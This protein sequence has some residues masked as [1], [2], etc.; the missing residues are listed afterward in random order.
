MAK[1]PTIKRI[2]REDLPDAPDWI[3]KLLY[4]VNKFFEDVFNALNRNLEFVDNVT[5]QKKDVTFK[6]LSTYVSTSATFETLEFPRTLKR[7][8]TG[9]LLL[10]IIQDED[11]H[12]PIETAPYIDW[13]DENGTI[14]IFLVT[15]LV[16]S[17]TYNMRVLL[18]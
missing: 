3:D 13:L 12:T 11:N 6:T 5:G 7:K 16:A 15:G 4:P 18:F 17:K 8:P 9:L 14:R 2:L 10:Q 1:L